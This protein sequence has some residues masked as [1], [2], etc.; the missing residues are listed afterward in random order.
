MYT[1]GCIKLMDINF[2]FQTAYG[3]VIGTIPRRQSVYMCAGILVTGYG[4]VVKVH[5]VGLH[6]ESL[7]NNR[8]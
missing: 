3:C 4:S 5:V 6:L 2:T 7:V 8:L 1:S